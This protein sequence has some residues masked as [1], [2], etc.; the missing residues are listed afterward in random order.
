MRPIIGVSLKYGLDK[1]VSIISMT[2]TLRRALQNLGADVMPI[3]PVIDDD[4]TK[5][6][7]KDFKKMREE[8]KINL[9]RFLDICDGI[10]MPGGN[11][12]LESDRYI[13]DY[14]IKNKIPILGICLSMQM[15]ACYKEDINIIKNTEEYQNHMQ[16]DTNVLHQHEIVIDKDS[17]LYKILGKNEISVNSLHE[18][19][20]EDN[21]YYKSVAY[22]KDGLIE[23]IEYPSTTFNM[24]VQWH[25]EKMVNDDEN[26]KK[27]M[28][29]F[30]NECSK[31]KKEKVTI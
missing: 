9:N 14:A 18:F 6:P 3:A 8:D 10:V 5:T 21:A 12:I 19:H 22:S 1:D 25:P 28:Q 26:Q 24:G 27:L 13:L 29:Y 2:E 11:K 31:N 17:K 7:L 23:A 15:M 4:S 16:E 20:I 30:I